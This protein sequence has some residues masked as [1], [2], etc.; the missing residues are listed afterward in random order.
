LREKIN[1]ILGKGKG[2]VQENNKE[3]ECGDRK[4]MRFA[5]KVNSLE[6]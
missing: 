3:K 5:S 2:K 4:K 6:K 1:K